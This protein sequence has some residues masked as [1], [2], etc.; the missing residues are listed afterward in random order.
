MLFGTPTPEKALKRALKAIAPA[1]EELGFKRERLEGA[2][3]VYRLLFVLDDGQLPGRGGTLF[4]YP[5]NPVGQQYAVEVHA[6]YRNDEGQI[7]ARR[8]VSSVSLVDLASLGSELRQ[9]AQAA[10]GQVASS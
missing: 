3:D 8:S 7:L 6:R 2:E 5:G 10:A 1:I 4:Y 9:A